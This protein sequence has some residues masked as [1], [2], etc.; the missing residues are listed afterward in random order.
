ML[1]DALVRLHERLLLARLELLDSVS[2]T[3]GL[4]LQGRA[5]L[6]EVLEFV[7][8]AVV[9]VDGEHVHGFELLHPVLEFR[10]LAL[11]AR[12]VG[13]VLGVVLADLRLEFVDLPVEPANLLAQVLEVALDALDLALLLVA[14]LLRRADLLAE[15]LPLGLEVREF[16]LEVG[17]LLVFLFQ[18]GFLLLDLRLEVRDRLLGV[19][20]LVL[21][22]FDGVVELL[23]GVL[24]VLFLEL[25]FVEVAVE[26]LHPGVELRDVLADGLRA[27][28]EFLH[29]RVL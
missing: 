1:V 5:L 16:L 18:G 8:D 4:L 21:G 3:V 20:L 17:H 9:L 23:D 19:G 10:D 14:G 13:D 12:E 24:G 6:G 15:L 28:V 29:L 22:R 25:E 11:H 2:D 26:V 7:F 27:V